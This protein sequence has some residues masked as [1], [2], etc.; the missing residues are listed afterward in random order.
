MH[1]QLI[2]IFQSSYGELSSLVPS[3]LLVGLG[4]TFGSDSP[5][6]LWQNGKG[7]LNSEIVTL[8]DIYNNQILSTPKYPFVVKL[9]KDL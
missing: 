5:A 8:Q 2:L 6:L 3:T 9:K 1:S 7:I 4:V